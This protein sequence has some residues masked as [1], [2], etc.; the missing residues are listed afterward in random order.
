MDFE[1]PENE[2]L[3][4]P[5][6]GSEIFSKSSCRRDC[7]SVAN[8]QGLRIPLESDGFVETSLTWRFRLRLAVKIYKARTGT[9]IF[10][11]FICGWLAYL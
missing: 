4:C 6:L 3:P 1:V 2:V 11:A 10:L 9:G 8:S 7:R 5:I